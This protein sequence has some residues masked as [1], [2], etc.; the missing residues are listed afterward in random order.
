MSAARKTALRCAC[1]FGRSPEADAQRPFRAK[2]LRPK[3]RDRLTAAGSVVRRNRHR[4]RRGRGRHSFEGA[5]VKSD[6]T[7]ARQARHA[8]RA[9]STSHGVSIPV[10]GSDALPDAVTNRAPMRVDGP[11]T[12][13][14]LATIAS[15]D[16][17]G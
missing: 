7:E 6:L 14:S 3:R 8:S 10:I 9:V 16:A 12:A 11:A 2:R 5:R 17:F 13:V 1:L 4:I 15:S